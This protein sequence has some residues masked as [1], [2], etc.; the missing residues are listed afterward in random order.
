MQYPSQIAP[1][2]SPRA[3]LTLG[4]QKSLE[5]APVCGSLR[6]LL[7]NVCRRKDRPHPPCCQGFQT[8]PKKRTGQRSLRSVKE[9]KSVMPACKTIVLELL[10]DRPALHEQLCASGT[11]L[12]SMQQ[13]AIALRSCHLDWMA[14]LAETRPGTE[15]TA[16]HGEGHFSLSVHSGGV[17]T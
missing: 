3:A 16:S 13:L 11:M 9:M 14:K 12:Q 7:S 10:Q 8:P 6:L 2:F 4:L 1:C 15:R 5:F 17:E